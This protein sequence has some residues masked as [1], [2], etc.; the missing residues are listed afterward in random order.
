TGKNISESLHCSPPESWRCLKN[1]FP[2]SVQAFNRHMRFP[3]LK[4]RVRE[5]I[6]DAQENRVRLNLIAKRSSL[7]PGCFNGL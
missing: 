5:G 2:D 7:N 1:Q 3:C 4:G 6:S